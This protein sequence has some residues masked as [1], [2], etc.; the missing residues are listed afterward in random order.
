MRPSTMI[1]STLLAAAGFMPAAQAQVPLLLPDHSVLA[2]AR[3][4]CWGGIMSYEPAS[5]PGFVTAS[6][7][8]ST[9]T[10]D[11]TVGYGVASASASGQV[12]LA[13]DY[14]TSRATVRVRDIWAD[15][16][17][18][19]SA[20]LAAGTP[21]QV[22]VGVTMDYAALLTAQQ[23]TGMHTQ[24][25]AALHFDGPDAPW[26]T[27]V[28][29]EYSNDGTSLQPSGGLSDRRSS[30]ALF[31]S[32]VGGSFTL[33]GDHYLTGNLG[34]NSA[35]GPNGGSM[36]LNGAAWFTVEVLTPDAGYTS[37][38]GTVYAPVPEPAAWALMLA[39]LAGLLAWRR[40][41]GGA[42]W[43]RQA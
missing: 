14:T 24:G 20:T 43:Q 42:S 1:V 10:V 40:R 18:I 21:V 16:F 34:A 30:S 35:Y 11:G 4:C 39:G 8:N 19:Q 38:S 6:S 27:G 26:I 25:I 31:N 28:T 5:G 41:D 23:G 13:P 9:A 15:S 2:E 12:L 32:T 37:G 7:W 17:S 3:H 22:R 33:F 36:T 29:F